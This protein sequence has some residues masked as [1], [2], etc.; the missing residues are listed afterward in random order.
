MGVSSSPLELA[1]KFEMLSQD[2]DRRRDE[3]IRN[4]AKVVEHSVLRRMASA[5]GGDMV[6]SG[7]TRTTGTRRGGSRGKVGVKTKV[8]TF[9]GNMSAT[10]RATGPAHLVESD[11]KRHP[12]VSRYAKG[13]AYT[14]TTKS[15]RVVR[16]RSSRQSRSASVLFGLG[17]AGGGRRA[18]LHWGGNN[19]ARYV[20]AESKGRHP[21][22]K[23]VSAAEPKASAE[24]AK[25]VAGSISR[26]F[27]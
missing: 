17:A 8:D 16:G 25:S 18:V 20:F 23:G 2:M 1:R 26:V 22:A 7:M 6:L 11:V 21:W 5:T 10:V 24:I 3:G 9:G 27:G 13:A 4:A 15:G 14:R 12:V 19:Y